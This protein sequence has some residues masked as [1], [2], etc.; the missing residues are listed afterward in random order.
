MCVA[1]G[2]KIGAALWYAHCI[3]YSVSRNG[4]KNTL[5]SH[6]RENKI[7][8]PL[9]GREFVQCSLGTTEE[10]VVTR[11]EAGVRC[12]PSG[13]STFMEECHVYQ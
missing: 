1:V 9:R 5:M 13:K 12:A 4:K 3:R 8:T 7:N 10:S 11:R 6:I 2:R